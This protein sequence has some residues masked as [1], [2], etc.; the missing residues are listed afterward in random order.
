MHGLVGKEVPRSKMLRCDEDL[1][2]TAAADTSRAQWRPQGHRGRKRSQGSSGILSGVVGELRVCEEGAGES[3][4]FQSSGRMHG[5]SEQE[6]HQ[7]TRQNVET[8]VFLL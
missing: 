1:H 7:R 6:G 3:Q 5:Q 8:P 2:P 4:T